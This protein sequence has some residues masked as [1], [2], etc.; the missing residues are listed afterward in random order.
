MQ[1]FQILG[2]VGVSFFVICLVLW[3]VSKKRGG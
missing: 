1:W 2:I 3:A